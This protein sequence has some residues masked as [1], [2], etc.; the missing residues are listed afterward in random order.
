MGI[1]TVG[2]TPPRRPR[3]IGLSHELVDEYSAARPSQL[4]GVG[5]DCWPRRSPP[6]TAAP[7]RRTRPIG[8]TAASTWVASTPTA[9]R[10]SCTCSP[11]ETVFLLQH[12]TKTG[13]RTC[14]ASTRPSATGWPPRVARCA[15]CSRCAPGSSRRCRWRGRVGGVD[16]DPVQT[17][18]RCPTARS[19]A[20]AHETL[21]IAMNNLG[22]R[23][24]RGGRRG[25]RPALRSAPAQRDQAGGVRPVRR[26][27]RSTWCRPPTSRSRWRRARSRGGRPAAAETRSGRGSRGP[28]TPPRA[29]G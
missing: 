21:A 20:E 10:A 6:G 9:G 29:S 3:G 19:S 2:R 15:G 8:C 14:S 16:P 25:H 4:G 18:A 22:A 23:P 24:T 27:Q 11:R 12:A 17:P 5:L 13:Q 28:G 7:T 1:S 26:D